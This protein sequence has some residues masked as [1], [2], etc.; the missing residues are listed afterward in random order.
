LAKPRFG[1]SLSSVCSPLLSP[2]ISAAFAACGLVIFIWPS[3]APVIRTGDMP[4]ISPQI[5]FQLQ[6]LSRLMSSS[7]SV[8]SARVMGGLRWWHFLPENG[9]SAVPEGGP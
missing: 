1:T 8:S 4:P 7:F 6:P 9:A 3:T 5:Y 2:N